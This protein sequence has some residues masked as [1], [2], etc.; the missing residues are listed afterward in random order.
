MIDN[1]VLENFREKAK[2]EGVGYQ[3]LINQTLRE[4]IG[5]RP[6]DE[7]TLGKVIREEMLSA[8]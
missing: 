7:A 5:F 4:S 2:T 3:T 8:T 1:G 6:V